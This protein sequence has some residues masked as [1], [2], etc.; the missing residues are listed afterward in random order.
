MSSDECRVTSDE[1]RVTRVEGRGA[2]GEGRGARGEGRG[3]RGERQKDKTV[4]TIVIEALVSSSI[5]RMEGS[6]PPS[7]RNKDVRGEGRKG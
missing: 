7:G 3:A 2:R 1:G 4:L 6:L 5:S